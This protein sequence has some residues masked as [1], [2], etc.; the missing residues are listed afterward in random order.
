MT[1]TVNFRNV[2]ADRR[3]VNLFMSF[4]ILTT[5]IEIDITVKQKKTDS[6]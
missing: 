5:Q 2:R 6:I 1:S 3:L 4:I